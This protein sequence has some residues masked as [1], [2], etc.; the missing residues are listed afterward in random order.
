MHGIDAERR[1]RNSHRIFLFEKCVKVTITKER[2]EEG[3]NSSE[4]KPYDKSTY[5]LIAALESAA[6]GRSKYL[7]N[8]VNSSE[9]VSPLVGLLYCLLYFSLARHSSCA[10]PLRYAKKRGILATETSASTS[11]HI[12][13][14]K[15]AMLNIFIRGAAS[16]TTYDDAAGLLVDV[17]WQRRKY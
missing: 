16:G 15:Q 14:K 10:F 13:S 9:G 8:A 1:I 5:S 4:S 7:V 3:N 11:H 6:S 12:R 2:C 17:L